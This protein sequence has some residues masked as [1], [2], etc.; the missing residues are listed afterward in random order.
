MRIL[1]PLTIDRYFIIIC[2]IIIDEY[3]TTYRNFTAEQLKEQAD[4]LT[5]EMD[6]TARMGNPFRQLAH[7]TVA[8]RKDDVDPKANHDIDVT[9]TNYRFKVEVKFLKNLRSKSGTYSNSKNWNEYQKD[10]NWLRSEIEAGNKGQRA[11]I[12]GWF[13]S[14]DYFARSMQLGTKAGPKPELNIERLKYF[15]FLKDVVGD[16]FC[17][18]Y[19][20]DYGKA[21]KQHTVCS[22]GEVDYNCIFLGT[23]DDKFHFALY[24]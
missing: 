10:F 1:L 21:Y 2:Q 23:P 22:V 6:L 12:I 15:P 8:D 3:N 14:L 18:D 24:Y 17:C 11:F 4:D 9:A 7:F 20:Y 5:S 19:K 13:N 16:N